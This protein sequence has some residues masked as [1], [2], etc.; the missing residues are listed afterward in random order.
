VVEEE[1]EV[2]EDDGE[3][4]NDITDDDINDNGCFS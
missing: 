2:E 4:M 1:E 3:L